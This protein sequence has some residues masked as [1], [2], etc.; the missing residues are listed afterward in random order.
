MSTAQL[1]ST[2]KLGRTFII[3]SEQIHAVHDVDLEVESGRLMVITGRSGSGKTTLLN[4][5]AGLD[6]PTAGKVYFEGQ[7]LT[8][9]SEWELTQLRRSKIGFVFQQF[10]LEP[11]LYVW[12]N[13][14]LPLICQDTTEDERYERAERILIK[15]GLDHRINFPAYQLSGGEQQRVA[16]ARALVTNPELIIA[17]EP[18]SSIDEKSAKKVV[19]IFLNLRKEKKS[20]VVAS[21]DL[22][23]W[24][25]IADLI[26]YMEDGM[27]KCSKERGK[28]AVMS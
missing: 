1:I 27:L 18:T 7:D 20:I 10:Y 6:T 14:A 25:K 22:Q 8:A 28:D 5:L 12:E 24:S 15:L 4:L 2:Q 17:D 16:I 26:Y 19:E 23:V 11:N 21:H 9:L 3:G 13:V